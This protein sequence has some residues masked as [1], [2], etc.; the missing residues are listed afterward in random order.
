MN[1]SLRP[2]ERVKVWRPQGFAGLEVEKLGLFEIDVPKLV[3]PTFD[4]T[5]V[6]R[7]A[8]RNVS[9]I[10]GAA[11]EMTGVKETRLFTSNAEIKWFAESEPGAFINVW[12]LKFSEACLTHFMV[13]LTGSPALPLLPRLRGRR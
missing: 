7:S 10:G 9:N 8:G 2:E 12:S 3:V 11:H 1:V 6:V 13:E 5:V 4:L